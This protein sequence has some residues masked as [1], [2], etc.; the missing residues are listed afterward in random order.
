MLHCSKGCIQ[1]DCAG[2]VDSVGKSSVATN[3]DTVWLCF[4]TIPGMK[5]TFLQPPVV[6]QTTTVFGLPLVNVD[7]HAQYFVKHAHLFGWPNDRQLGTTVRQ[8]RVW[9]G[10]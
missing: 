6:C 4:S 7:L 8:S 5:I 9:V 3:C 1:Y 2:S 10:F